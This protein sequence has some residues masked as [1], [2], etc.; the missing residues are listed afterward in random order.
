M[1]G[2]CSRTP[3]WENGLKPWSSSR[4]MPRGWDASEL[5]RWCPGKACPYK[6]PTIHR[7]SGTCSQSQSRETPE[8]EIRRKNAERFPKKKDKGRKCWKIKKPE[9]CFMRTPSPSIYQYEN[10]ARKGSQAS[11]SQQRGQVHPGMY[12]IS[13]IILDVKKKEENERG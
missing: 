7:V 2:R 10:A 12:T 6:I 11:S 13:G 8:T 4:K 5:N 3:K 9:W 1:C